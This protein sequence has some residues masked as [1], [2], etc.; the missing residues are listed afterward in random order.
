[1]F[2]SNI[3]RPGNDRRIMLFDLSIKGHHPTY[4]QHLIEYWNQR[5][6]PGHLDI[7]VSPRFLTEHADVVA[8]ASHSSQDKVQFSAITLEEETRLGSRKASFDRFFRA[9]REWQLLCKYAKSLKASQ[10]LIMYF[11]TYQ[12]PLAWGVT[13]PCSVSGIYFR[14]TFHYSEFTHYLPSWQDRLQQRRETL[15]LSRLWQHPQ[16]KILFCLDPFAVKH[17]NQFHGSVRAV[18]LPDPVQVSNFSKAEPKDIREDL[19]IETGRLVFLLFGALTE[20]KGIH[21]LLEA[22]LALSPTLCQKICLLF[23]GESNIEAALEVKIKEICQIQPIQIVR[24]YEFVPEQDVQAYFQGADVIL[25]PYQRHVGMSGILLLAAAARKP[26]LSSDYG[27]MG[28]MVQRYKLGLTVDSTIAD[29]IMKGLSRF[30]L[31]PP[32]QLCDQCTMKTFAEQ[33]SVE[34]FADTIFENL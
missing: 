13:A 15:F 9:F 14:P 28:E 30:L 19:G 12:A 22:I 6:L 5:S 33:N 20:R 3:R 18:H 27:L 17:L 16:F 7:V 2:A 34:R 10:C 23:V 31:E 25:A 21:Q 32:T 4:I 26:V 11:D 29:E 8:L 24:R 1:M